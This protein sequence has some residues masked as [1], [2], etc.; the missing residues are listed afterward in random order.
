[1]TEPRERA[2]PRRRGAA[3][4]RLG[5]AA[6]LLIALAAASAHAQHTGFTATDVPAGPASIHGKVVHS[7][8]P[9]AAAGVEVVL[10]ALPS[11]GVPGLRRT[12][13]DASGA[14]AFEG[15]SNSPEVAYLVGA[16]FANIPFPGSRI[17]FA[18]GETDRAT[19]VRIADPTTDPSAVSVVE[20]KLRLDR[21]AAGLAVVETHELRNAGKQVVFVPAPARSKAKPAFAADLLPGA[22]DLT[23]PLGM[24]P[25]GLV[26]RPGGLAFFGPIYPG[27]Q[28]LT[29]SYDVPLDAA[30]AR[31]LEKRFPSAAKRVLVLASEAVGALHAPGFVPTESVKDEDKSYRALEAKRVPEGATLDL[32][33]DLPPM[34]AEP[35]ALSVTEVRLVLDVDDA[36]VTVQEEHALQVSEGPPLLGSSAQPLLWIPLPAGAQDV[37]FAAETSAVGLVPDS[38][39]GLDVIGPLPAGESSLRIQ[40]RVPVQEGAV[41]LDRPFGAAFPL[42]SVFVADSGI[43]ADSERLH[44]RRPVRTED[45][46]YLHL[47]AFEIAPGET[48]PLRLAALPPAAGVPAVAEMLLV[49]LLAAAAVAILARPVLRPRSV[50]LEAMQATPD[51]RER[52]S[53]YSALR[54]LEDDFETGKV[55]EPDYRTLREELRGRALAL[56]QVERDAERTA[57]ERARAPQAPSGPSSP[58]LCRACGAVPRPEDRFCGRCGAP[59]APPAELEASA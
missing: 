37:R 12:Q 9:E 38:R 47:E 4:G 48:V 19:E 58:A 33:L 8:R 30:G 40:Y 20:S 25:D 59:L 42:L 21:S 17:A 44:R 57:S 56:L 14:F 5:R 13:T 29:F 51:H 23:H 31:V 45:R 36:A 16:R 27:E 54:D 35:S 43:T 26:D 55:A 39:G 11:S 53:L 49:A 2:A 50:A 18:Q 3:A 32:A 10:Y 34:R 22:K 6:T 15:I 28:E 24:K 46:A 1:M 52:D 41:A 7:E